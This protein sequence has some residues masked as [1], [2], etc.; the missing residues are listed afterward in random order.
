M[1]KKI[2]IS[3]KAQK[4]A[5]KGDFIY[6]KKHSQRRNL[7]MKS[8]GH[9]EENINFLKNKGLS[10]SIDTEFS[11]GVRFVHIDRHFN[12]RDTRING[13]TW[14]PKDWDRG[15]IR[16]AGEHVASLKRNRKLIDGKRHTGR[17]R[18][19]TVGII[20][21]NGMLKTIFPFFDVNKHARNKSNI[22]RKK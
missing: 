22:I 6:L 16:K 17:Y 8:G 5:S 21:R 1:K 14:F 18:G 15:D 11:N 20:A 9:G 13:H 4:H 3:Q 7:T 19:V 12:K 2:F 10:Y